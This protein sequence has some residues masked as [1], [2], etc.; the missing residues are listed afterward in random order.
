MPQLMVFGLSERIDYYGR[1][2]MGAHS[3]ALPELN[4]SAA[5][6]DTMCS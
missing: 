1:L 3:E 6:A 4:R 2:N 5:T